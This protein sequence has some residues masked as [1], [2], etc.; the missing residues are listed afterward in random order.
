MTPTASSDQRLR[1]FC[2]QQG[3]LTIQ[4]S[5]CIKHPASPQ[6]WGSL[7]SDGASD[8]H[9]L[10]IDLSKIENVE[11]VTCVPVFE[12]NP[13]SPANAATLFS[14]PPFSTADRSL[15][16]R[17]AA[18]SST[19]DTNYINN[20]TARRQR[21]GSFTLGS[22]DWGAYEY[23][24]GSMVASDSSQGFYELNHET[25]VNAWVAHGVNKQTSIDYSLSNQ[26]AKN[27]FSPLFGPTDDVGATWDV[28]DEPI[29]NVY[30]IL[31]NWGVGGSGLN[32]STIISDDFVYGSMY[33]LQLAANNG[34]LSNALAMTMWFGTLELPGYV[35]PGTQP[36][37]DPEGSPGVLFRTYDNYVQR[38]AELGQLQD[39]TSEPF[40]SAQAFANFSHSMIDGEGGIG[41]WKGSLA[42]T[43]K[44]YA[45]IARDRAYFDG[46]NSDWPDVRQQIV[47]AGGDP[48]QNSLTSFTDQ[49][50]ETAF[51]RFTGNIEG[52]VPSSIITNGTWGTSVRAVVDTYLKESSVGDLTVLQSPLKDNDNQDLQLLLNIVAQGGT[53][54]YYFE[55]EFYPPGK[56]FGGP[57]LLG[58][59]FP[60]Q[61]LFTGALTPNQNDRIRSRRNGGVLL[62]RPSG[63][64][65]NLT[66]TANTVVN[67]YSQLGTYNSNQGLSKLLPTVPGYLRINTDE[68]LQDERPSSVEILSENAF[69]IQTAGDDAT[70]KSFKRYSNHN[71]GILYYDYFGRPGSV[72]PFDPVYV[73]GYSQAEEPTGGRGMTSIT[74]TFDTSAPPDWAHSYR[75]VYGG[76]SSI[77]DF[78]QYTTGGAFVGSEAFD[79][80]TEETEG[81][82][83]VSLNYLQENSDVSFSKAFGAV[84]NA[85]E[86]LLYKFSPGDKL[87]VISYFDGE[88]LDTRQFP[89]NYEF[90]ILDV[91]TLADNTE[92]P[93]HAANNGP[94]PKFKQGQFLILNNNPLA[95]GFTY[96]SVKAGG[97]AA[98]TTA[99]KWNNRAVVEIY[100]PRAVRDTDEI[101]YREVGPAYNIVTQQVEGATVATHEEASHTITDGDVWF[102]SNA[103]NMPAVQGNQFKN[104]IRESGNSSPRFRPYYV[105]SYR[106]TDTFPDT[107][108][109]GKGKPF[110]YS[111][112]ARELNKS[113]SII[114][115]D[116]NPRSSKYNRFS[117]FDATTANFKNVPNDHG[118]IQMIMKDGDSLATFQESKMS[119]LPVNR[120]VLSDASNS[121]TLLASAQTIGNQVFVPGSYGVG[122]NPESVLYVDGFMYFA[123]P[124]RKEVYRY[125]PSRGVEVISDS[126]M[127]DYFEDL[128]KESNETSKVVSGF[129]YQNSEYLIDFVPED[130][131]ITYS[132]SP[133]YPT[134]PAGTPPDEGERLQKGLIPPLVITRRKGKNKKTIYS[135]KPTSFK[136]VTKSASNTLSKLAGNVVPSVRRANSRRSSY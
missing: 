11:I 38:A 136:R 106:F 89:Y 132:T 4:A 9:Y 119:M 87:R 19:T 105:E 86:D 2:G 21:D 50:I 91:V 55:Q 33:D 70:Y 77:S 76:N 81:N 66:D 7:A 45:P 10:V 134:L 26:E 49:E 23:G 125:A 107:R 42:E 56:T 5:R 133:T 62:G 58:F 25:T 3:G 68:S 34:E 122:T 117:T 69:V 54:T 79:G 121:A 90:D 15:K 118:S 112:D 40:A 71:I 92:N 109:S 85:N 123:N 28:D 84:S 27:L 59:H 18:G 20:S 103:L 94:V 128:F 130:S 73:A 97:N 12:C 126:G 82:I 22:G 64:I 16:Y 35:P 75:F 111:P 83:Y 1:V 131:Q 127:R 46:N 104:I 63:D 51:R 53:F 14:V 93:I 67:S 29:A 48:T 108:V 36:G 116:L 24:G 31:S 115:S 30:H 88:D 57:T 32:S 98:E 114:F 41:G 95:S 124:K 39:S 72:I 99:H 43:A 37:Q 65:D 120:S 135:T 8:A 101:L 17:I 80:T 78:I 102:R 47:D 113:S 60:F 129:D 52:S 13:S 6:S 61:Y 100:S 110:I 96:G 44:R 74:A